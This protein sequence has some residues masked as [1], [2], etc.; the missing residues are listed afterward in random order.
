MTTRE[1][2]EGETPLWHSAT[3]H[4]FLDELREGTLDPWVDSLEVAANRVLA[5]GGEAEREAFRW[6]LR[7]ERDF[8][9]MA[10]GGGDG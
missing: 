6:I 1:L 3:N 5:R 8:W 10:Y 2:I 7:Y 9:Q 4:P